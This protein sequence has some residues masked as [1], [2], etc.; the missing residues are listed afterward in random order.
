MAP[1]RSALLTAVALMLTG[2]A[3]SG[4]GGGDSKA[5]TKV[6]TPQGVVLVSHD[7]YKP[8]RIEVPVG[9]E[10][11]WSV[12]NGSHTVVADDYSFSSP[13]MSTGEFRHTFTAPGTYPYHCVILP[14]M[15]GTVVVTG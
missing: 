1:I 4:G 9:K 2:A 10:V 3:C 11:V 6:T 7:G 12:E 14:K 5:S 13:I 15:K 8:D